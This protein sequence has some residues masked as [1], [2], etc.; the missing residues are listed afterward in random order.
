MFAPGL[1]PGTSRR[2]LHNGVSSIYMKGG[3]KC[4]TY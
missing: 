4:N 3:D 2:L 1:N